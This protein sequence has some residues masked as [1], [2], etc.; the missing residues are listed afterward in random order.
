MKYSRLQSTEAPKPLH[1]VENRAAIQFL[2]L[3]DAFDE[4]FAPHVAALLAFLRQLP[5][6]HHLCGDAGMIGARKPQGDEP[7]HA[8]PAHDNVHLRL[9]EHVAHVKAA[10]YVGRRRRSVKTGRVS[11]GGGVTTANSFSLIQ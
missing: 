4:F 10:G 6:H 7:A 3:P 9:V 5:L 2:P 1:L 11:P 8:V